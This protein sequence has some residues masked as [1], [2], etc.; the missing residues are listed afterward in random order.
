[1]EVA[2]PLSDMLA[3]AGLTV[4]IDEAEIFIGDSL[5]E[6]I[7]SG[8]AQSQFGIVILSHHFFAKDWPKSE[9]DGLF[10]REIGG[11]KVLLPVWHK[12]TY[13]E[14]KKYSPLLAG[15]MAANT[16]YGLNEVK[17]KI[18]MAI[19]KIGRKA[20]AGKPIYNGRLLKSQLMNFPEGSYLVSN[21]YSSFDGKPSFDEQIG[22]IET[23][24]NL[25]EK[26]KST[27]A[28]GR[29]CYV[30]KDYDDYKAHMNKSVMWRGLQRLRDRNE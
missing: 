17:E 12:I 27:G 23:R 3:A 19:N 2:F 1:M 28:D 10:A 7:D 24:M 29:L 21:T 26:I 16:E 13:N 11:D 15:K 6:K 8:L 4:W 9:L 30:F 22:S 20:P 5:R 14:I 25:W 18:L